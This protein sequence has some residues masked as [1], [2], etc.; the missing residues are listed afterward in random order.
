MKHECLKCKKTFKGPDFL[1]YHMKMMHFG[2]K[3]V[4]SPENPVCLS[5]YCDIFECP[6]QGDKTLRHQVFMNRDYN[7]EGKPK[8]T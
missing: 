6:E 5:D 4:W 8:Q 2:K 1:E 3:D 7:Y